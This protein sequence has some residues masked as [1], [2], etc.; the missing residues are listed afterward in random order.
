MIQRR[1]QTLEGITYMMRDRKQGISTN[2]QGD[3]I[4]QTTITKTINIIQDTETIRK[5]KFNITRIIKAQLDIG[6]LYISRLTIKGSQ[7]ITIL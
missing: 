3:T 7:G 1:D 2:H 5:D 6:R 4:I